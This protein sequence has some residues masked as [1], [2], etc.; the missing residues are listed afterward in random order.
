MVDNAYLLPMYEQVKEM[1]LEKIKSGEIP[2]GSKLPSERELSQQ[3]NISRMT[4]RSALTALVNEGWAFRQ[5][6]KGTF[7]ANPKIERDLMKLMG[8]SQMLKE[9]GLVPTNTVINSRVIEADKFIAK[10]LNLSIGE[11]VYQIVRLR[12]GNN[13]PIALEY[14]YLPVK[15]F[16]NLLNYDFHNELLYRLIE[17][18]YNI[19][20]KF[21]KQYVSIAKADESEAGI[22]EIAPGEPILILESITYDSN[23][24]P[25]EAT[26]S[27][28]RGDRCVFYTELWKNSELV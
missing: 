2:S 16:P 5:Q 27:L 15:L 12:C 28:T 22:L 3:Y 9:K 19:K 8:F 7:V 18:H 25:V 4:A 24:R 11:N 6:G 20:M 17:E 10:K 13:V 1:L 14:S 23:D 26:R 21:A